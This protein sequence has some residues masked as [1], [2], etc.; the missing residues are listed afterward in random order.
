MA[1]TLKVIYSDF[2]GRAE[3]IRLALHL[4]KIPF[5]DQRISH[6]EWQD[7]KPQTPFGQ[8]PVLEIDGKV[9]VPSVIVPY[10]GD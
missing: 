1:P 5:E 10:N 2:K 3:P 7:L 6:Q 4:G 9:G 8:M